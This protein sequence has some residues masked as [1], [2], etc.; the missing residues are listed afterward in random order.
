[1]KDGLPVPL[2]LVVP[3][4]HVGLGGHLTLRVVVVL[5][6]GICVGVELI[7]VDVGII[8]LDLGDAHLADVEH[9]LG[10]LDV[11][12]LRLP[13]EIQEVYLLDADAAEAAVRL[14]IP[15]NVEHRH[16]VLDL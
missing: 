2:D 16:T 5:L 15:E 7:H 6:R 3:I 14:R 10:I 8:A 12:R 11:F 4:Y 1:M 9:V 13:E